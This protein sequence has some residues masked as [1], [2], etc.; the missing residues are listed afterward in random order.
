MPKIYLETT[1]FNYYLDTDRGEAHVAT[2]ELFRQIADGQFEP[3]T[4][5]YVVNELEA[6]PEPKRSQMLNLITEYGVT[7]LQQSGEAVDLAE[8]YVAAGVIPEKYR[9]DGLHIATAA[10]YDMDIIVSLNFTHIVKRKT[11]LA[12]PGINA[13]RGYRSVEIYNPMEVINDDPEKQD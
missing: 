3:Y 5:Y 2:L 12:T 11:K 8:A 10:V 6:A 9:T 1:I 7:V 13:L 4:S